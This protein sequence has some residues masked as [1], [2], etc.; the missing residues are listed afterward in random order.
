V[1]S[2]SVT[3]STSSVVPTSWCCSR[4]LFLPPPRA[5]PAFV[6]ALP[7]ISS[8]WLSWRLSR[9]GTT[10]IRADPT[11]GM[12]FNAP[13]DARS[14]A[15]KR[16]GRRWHGRS[17]LP[18]LVC[19]VVSCLALAFAALALVPQPLLAAASSGT[20]GL[21]AAL[22][23][24]IA[25]QVAMVNAPTS[26]QL[27]GLPRCAGAWMDDVSTPQLNVTEP[28]RLKAF[29]NQAELASSPFFATNVASIVSRESLATAAY[30]SSALFFS[31]PSV[32]LDLGAPHQVVGFK[33]RALAHS[34]SR[35]PRHLRL[36]QAASLTL[37]PDG[38]TEAANNDGEWVL[39]GEHTTQKI[40]GWS[41]FGSWQPVPATVTAASTMHGAGG[42][43]GAASL[44]NVSL[45]F[46]VYLG[47]SAQQVS[48]VGGA[49]CGMCLF[50]F[51][52]CSVC[53]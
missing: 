7:F 4:T 9:P 11:L 24:T 10:F 25:P 5:F 8:R 52:G 44:S 48:G 39:V 47:N 51:V 13:L 26:F 32:M 18:V 20:M 15:A 50:G 27:F 33:L 40:D 14:G 30:S 42:E 41:T 19:R 2:G 22:D 45:S 12:F 35:A 1:T 31:L 28:Q 16:W 36:W 17:R 46:H 37:A 6:P 3:I 34:S 29:V 23:V 43:D 53:G 38:S 49:G 21:P